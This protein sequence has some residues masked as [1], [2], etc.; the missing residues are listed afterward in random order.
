[1]KDVVFIGNIAY[2]TEYPLIGQK[3]E[4]IVG[5]GYFTYTAAQLASNNIGIIA[6]IGNDLDLSK[7]RIIKDKR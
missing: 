5:S 3:I 2:Q 7:L 6:R 1:M 4:H